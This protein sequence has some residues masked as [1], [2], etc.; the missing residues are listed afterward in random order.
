MFEKLIWKKDRVLLGELV[1]RLQHYIND[2]W[3]LAENCFRFFKI[4]ALVDEY[5]DFFSSHKNF[6]PEN[7]FELGLY[8]GGSIVFW[9]EHLQPQKHV[10]IDLQQKIDNKYFQNYLK[11]K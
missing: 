9:F 5:E 7:I 1:F 6:Q 10:G 3:D 4:K 11:K 8:E 2:D